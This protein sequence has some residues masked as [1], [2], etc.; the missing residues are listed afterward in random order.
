MKLS[1]QRPLALGLLAALAMNTSAFAQ[2]SSPQQTPTQQTPTQQTPTYPSSSGTAQTTPSGQ[3]PATSA[4]GGVVGDRADN[5]GVNKRDRDD[6]SPLPS[7]QSNDSSALHLTA[8]VRQAI[9]HDD[10]LSVK[11]HNVKVIA[12]NGV[13]ILRGPVASAQEK[14]RVEQ[15]VMRVQGV[16]RVD[17]RL[18]IED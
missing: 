4:E 7:Q 18:D 5:T 16:T 12:D 1:L 9:V 3:A 11:A 6:A 2:Q 13:V 17:N 14:S 10:S 8:D 15:D